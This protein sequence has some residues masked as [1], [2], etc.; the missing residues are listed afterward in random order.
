MNANNLIRFAFIAI[1]GALLFFPFLGQV[2]LFDWDEIN[3]AECAREMIVTKDYLKVQIDFQPFWEKPPLFI[4]MQVLSMKL[5]G[6]NEY[7]ARFPNAFMG[8]LTLV[9]LYYIGKR[10]VNEKMGMWWAVLY[11]GTWLPHFYFKSGIIDPTFNFF[12]FLAF[13]QMHLIRHGKNPFNHALLTGLFLGLAVLTKG[14]VAILIALLALGAYAIL[15]KGFWGYPI[16][17]FIIITLMAALPFGLWFLACI[18]QY[19]WHYGSWFIIEFIRY[20]I[21]LFTTGDAGHGQPF[22][23]HFIV[24]LIGCFPASLFLFQYSKK[25]TNEAESSKDFT[26]WMW[27]LFW[28][29]LLLFSIV[30][31]KIVH[32]SS[33]CYFPLTY[34]AAL[35][36]AAIAEADETLKT[37]VKIGLAIIGSLLA[38]LIAFLP[39]VGIYKTSLIPFIQDPFAVANLSAQVSWGWAE[40]LWGFAY[41]II[42]V[43]SLIW[44]R[45]NFIRAMRLL[46]IGTI[47]ILQVTV[48]HFTPKI[49]AYSQRAAIRY[50]KGFVGKD[51]YIHVLGYKSYAHYFYAETQPQNNPKRR[52]ESWLLK[53]DVD[54]P[55]YFICKITAAEPYKHSKELKLLGEKNG[56]VFFKRIP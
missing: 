31:T 44:M 34:L 12:I 28:V 54:K 10:V 55:T 43:V 16:R 23:Y 46:L 5:F 26:R 6:I 53:G 50:F 38:L 2:H 40:S 35:K 18:I 45:K 41:L 20:Q 49:E 15:N 17:Y 47:I 42:I 3:F 27:L 25:R 19:G 14:P 33:L 9:T 30:K 4:W 36:I 24:L 1:L 39:L 52:D 11:A 32:Y 51:V 48:L 37:R 13:F 7:A 21:R 56:F 22:Y 29:T 8:V